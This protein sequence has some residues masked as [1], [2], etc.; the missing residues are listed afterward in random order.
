MIQFGGL[1]VFLIIFGIEAQQPA[2]EALPVFAVQPDN[3]FSRG[4]QYY[5]LL[6]LDPETSSLYIGAMNHV[7][8]VWMYNVNDTKN[9]AFFA[10][11]T[12]LPN[13]DAVRTCSFQQGNSSYH[14]QNHIRVLLKVPNGPLYV[15]GT[16][17]YKPQVLR[18]NAD[19][20]EIIKANISGTAECPLSPDD[21]STA[22]FVEHGNPGGIASIYSGSVTTQADRIIYRPPLEDSSGQR[23]DFMRTFYTDSRWLNDADFVASFDVGD[24]FVYFFFREPAVETANCGKAI[25]S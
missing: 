7:Y 5:R 25:Y 16:N 2:N 4:T 13:A 1:F 15:C 3:V 24:E 9:E 18:L 6:E 20:L 19:S 8:R 12:L 11:Q 17:A 23:F 10:T 22:V 21:Q 14:C